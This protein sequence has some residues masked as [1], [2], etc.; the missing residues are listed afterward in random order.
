MGVLWRSYGLNLWI[1][2]KVYDCRCG[3]IRTE[4]VRFLKFNGERQ[5]CTMAICLNE[6]YSKKGQI[7]SHVSE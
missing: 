1:R 5:Q 7:V 6:N 2:A 3:F 4:S